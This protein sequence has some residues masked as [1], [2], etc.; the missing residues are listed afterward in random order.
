MLVA[1]WR[2]SGIGKVRKEIGGNV[3]HYRKQAGLSQ[4]RLAEQAELHPVSISQVE[5][6]TKAVSV[7]ALWKASRAIL[8][9]TGRKRFCPTC[10][11]AT[12]P[13]RTGSSPPGLRPSWGQG[14]KRDEPPVAPGRGNV[15]LTI[16][17]GEVGS[18]SK[19]DKGEAPAILLWY[20]GRSMVVPYCYQGTPR[21]ARGVLASWNWLA[22]ELIS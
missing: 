18:V 2:V 10:S 19:W 4:E 6:G 12:G 3:C 17:G 7:E 14:L 21:P 22:L 8:P 15:G 13:H 9:E 1:Y 5:R 16:A 20:H 11:K